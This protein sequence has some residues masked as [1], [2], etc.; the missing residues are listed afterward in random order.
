MPIRHGAMVVENLRSVRIRNG[1]LSEP[2]G[3]LKVRVPEPLLVQE[4]CL[5]LF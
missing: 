3:G 1:G 5:T 4:T 2:N